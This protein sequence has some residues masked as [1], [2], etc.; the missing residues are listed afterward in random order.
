MRTRAKKRCCGGSVIA[1]RTKPGRRAPVGAVELSV[2]AATLA[3]GALSVLEKMG[4]PLHLRNEFKAPVAAA[5]RLARTW[6]SAGAAA[7]PIRLLE[8][9][10]SREHAFSRTCLPSATRSVGCRGLTGWMARTTT[11]TNDAFWLLPRGLFSS[12]A[13]PNLRLRRPAGSR[14]VPLIRLLLRADATGSPVGSR[15]RP[16]CPRR[17][18]SVSY[19]A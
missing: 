17:A 2:N 12:S 11:A 13:R 9:G 5:L 7:G 8:G 14:A 15:R 3:T 6:G 18:V 19:C 10:R 4:L 16:R 1:E